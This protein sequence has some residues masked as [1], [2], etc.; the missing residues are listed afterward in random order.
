[1]NILEL[2]PDLEGKQQPGVVS[3]S[4]EAGPVVEGGFVG[5]RGYSSAPGG[6]G[7]HSRHPTRVQCR[8]MLAALGKP[9]R[10]HGT[11]PTR[12]VGWRRCVAARLGAMIRWLA[13]CGSL[14]LRG[15]G[16]GP[17]CNRSHMRRGLRKSA[18]RAGTDPAAS[19]AALQVSRLWTAGQGHLAPVT[20]DCGAWYAGKRNETSRG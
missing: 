14:E 10:P 8:W 7:R 5:H 12:C 4:S 20:R 3:I 13:R 1:M 16:I 18:G 11:C 15:G 2:E 6:W 19:R 17:L 9:P